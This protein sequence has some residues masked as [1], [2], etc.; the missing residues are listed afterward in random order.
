MA[1]SFGKRFKKNIPPFDFEKAVGK[2]LMETPRLSANL[3]IVS[4]RYG[5]DAF[6]CD[7]VADTKALLPWAEEHSKC[8]FIGNPEH[9]AANLALPLLLRS[10][11]LD[12]KSWSY[13]PAACYHATEA[14]ATQH[15]T[16]GIAKVYCHSCKSFVDPK[17]EKEG[18]AGAVGWGWW[19]EV[20]TCP[21]GA[22]LLRKECEMRIARFYSGKRNDGDDVVEAQCD[23]PESLPIPK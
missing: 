7:F 9:Q 12:D 2:L 11:D 22:N 23:I 3:V 15:V 1:W 16:N 8:C 19:T 17:K 4:Q 6:K 13:F 10:A 18:A 20:W 5:E 21:C 14:W